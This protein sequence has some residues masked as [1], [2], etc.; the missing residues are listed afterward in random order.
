MDNLRGDQSYRLVRYWSG[1]VTSKAGTRRLCAILTCSI[2]LASALLIHTHT[3]ACIRTRTRRLVLARTLKEYDV[4]QSCSASCFSRAHSRA[5]L[6]LICNIIASHTRDDSRLHGW[7][8]GSGFGVGLWFANQNG[9][10]IYWGWPDNPLHLSPLSNKTL[11][12]ACD[13]L[14]CAAALGLQGLQRPWAQSLTCNPRTAA[15]LIVASHTS[16]VR[17]YAG[18]NRLWGW[19]R[20]SQSKWK[21][22]LLGLVRQRLSETLKP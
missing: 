5:Q 21:C 7:D 4:I 22:G 8:Q 18:G 15:I 17:A 1:T 19:I 12:I 11:V 2:S 14:F 10:V 3:R 6:R 13:L 16:V 20:V 9:S